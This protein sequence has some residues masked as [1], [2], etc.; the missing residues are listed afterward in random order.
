M[1][2]TYRSRGEQ[3]QAQITKGP[4]DKISYTID[5]TDGAL[6]TA[7]LSSTS[8]G[9]LTS[10]AQVT[11][12]T[13]VGTTTISGMTVQQTTLTMGT[14][15]TQAAID[16]SRFRLSTAVTLSNG[17]VLNYDVFVLVSAAAYAPAS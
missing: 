2:F 8:V 6:G 5:F 9:A 4:L 14:T 10:A 7:T 13:C 12:T 11:T 16:G 1:I 3:N 17:E 15:G